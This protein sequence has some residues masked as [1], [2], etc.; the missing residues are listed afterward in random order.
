M[1][2]LYVSTLPLLIS[3]PTCDHSPTLATHGATP[4]QQGAGLSTVLI[5]MM[6][7]LSPEKPLGQLCAHFDTAG[8]LERNCN[9]HLL[10]LRPFQVV[11]MRT[12]GI[13]CT[14]SSRNQRSSL[15]LG[16]W[17]SGSQRYFGT[18]WKLWGE[19]CTEAVNI[20]FF[21]LVVRY[22]QDLPPRWFRKLW[23]LPNMLNMMFAI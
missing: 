15:R 5:A 18:L 4:C 14:K 10:H 21:Q 23:V 20:W 13:M 19:N 1:L 11:G 22:L 16:P 12:W 8:K 7:D 3:L 17:C 6:P 9:D 2:Q